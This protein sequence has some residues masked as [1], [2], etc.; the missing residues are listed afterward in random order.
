MN[1]CRWGLLVDCGYD[2]VYKEFDTQ[3]ELEVYIQ[4]RLE[5]IGIDTPS[6]EYFL[7]ELF[8]EGVASESIDTYTLERLYPTYEIVDGNLLEDV[9]EGVLEVVSVYVN[10]SGDTVVALKEVDDGLFKVH[11]VQDIYAYYKPRHCNINENRE[12]L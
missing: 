3:Q 6:I 2:S 12:E 5:R 8:D 11:S 1:K 10:D 4:S 9:G 7:N